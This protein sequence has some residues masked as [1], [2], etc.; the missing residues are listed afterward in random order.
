[1][2][3]VILISGASSGFGKQA[4]ARL[5]EQGHRVYGAARRLGEMQDL[6]D[7]G[8]YALPMDVS[9][10]DDIAS[11]VNTVIGQQGR[12]DVLINNAGFGVYDFVETADL[13]A[14][15]RMFDVNF[16]GLVEL[17]QEV[18]P[19][20]RA[21]GQGRVVN[22][23]SLAGQMSFSML[24]FYAA[25]KHAVEA[26][27]DALRRETAE[28]GIQVSLV[29]PGV[30]ATGFEEVMEAERDEYVVD[31]AYANAYESFQKMSK[32]AYARAPQPKPVV[33]AMI[34]AAVSKR[35][36]TRYVVGLD[37]KS[38]LAMQRMMSDG[39]VDRMLSMPRKFF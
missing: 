1:M 29:E 37:A 23:S 19:H 38:A 36:K 17:T 13:A 33:D 3:K 10:A 27:S 32:V 15:R 4:A 25:T 39:A 31:P 2:N 8:G 11:C 24:G 26:I 7:M 14:M 22:I 35:P 18:L 34:K 6:V 20:M 9:N 28:F 21:Q 16:W 30:F 12:I 5:I